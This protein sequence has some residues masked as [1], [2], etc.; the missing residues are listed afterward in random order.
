MK[1]FDRFCFVLAFVIGCAFLVLGSLGL[2]LGCKAH[3]TLPP[4][5]GVVPALVG[6]GITRAVYLAWRQSTVITPDRPPSWDDAG[7]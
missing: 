7:A 5:L 6:W 4:V 3:F 1:Y 2:F